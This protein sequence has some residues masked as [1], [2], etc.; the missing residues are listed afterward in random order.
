MK[1]PKHPGVYAITHVAS[2]RRYIG[3]ARNIYNRWRT[4]KSDLRRGI[5]PSR[6][7]QN[8]WNKHGE[9][10]FRFEVLEACLGD[11]VLLCAREQWWID[12]S[13]RK[14]FNL[15]SQADPAFGIPRTADQKAHMSRVMTGNKNGEGHHFHGHLT[16]DDVRDIMTRYAAGETRESLSERYKTHVV[17]ISRIASRR[18]WW[19]VEVPPEIA[20][21]CRE[22]TKYRNRGAKNGKAKLHNHIAEIKAR[23]NDGEGTSSIAKSFGVT[24]CAIGAIKAGRS[25]AYDHFQPLEVMKRDPSTNS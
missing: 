3:S 25:Y 13:E 4:H 14:L 10:A 11:A 8:A 23:I 5:S 12:H 7:L 9:T 1:Y 6:H 22:R 20:A 21:A 24:P 2:G 17:N 16:E 19:R 18:I 15:R